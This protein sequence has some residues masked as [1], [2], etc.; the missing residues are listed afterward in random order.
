MNTNKIKCPVCENGF[1]LI[2][3][4]NLLQGASFSCSSCATT[5]GLHSNSVD[6]FRESLK[7][8]QDM[9]NKNIER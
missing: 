7:A 8:Y 5:L 1:I 6:K 3:Y 4:N 2:E 9:A